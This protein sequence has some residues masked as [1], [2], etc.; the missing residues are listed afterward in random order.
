MR[1]KR[2]G[3]I[4]TYLEDIADV[5]NRLQTRGS[6]EVSP[7]VALFTLILLAVS[8]AYISPL[9]LR[10]SSFL[11]IAAALVLSALGDRLKEFLRMIAVTTF[12]LGVISTPLVFFTGSR[13]EVV[14]KLGLFRTKMAAEGLVV[15]LSFFLRCL[16]TT[17]I[18]LGWVCCIRFDSLL[19]GLCILDPT[20]T[21]STL[22]F[23]STRY[24]PLSL[25]EAISLL[26]AREARTMKRD[27]SLSWKALSS[28]GG[29]L[30][31]R[32]I[33]RGRRVG[34][35]ISA[36]SLCHDPMPLGVKKSSLSFKS[37]DLPPISIAALYTVIY[38]L[39]VV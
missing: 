29:E 5:L 12:S 35:A 9:P 22:L 38:A 14:L 28:T 8:T 10:F 1:G 17:S 32:A 20:Q 18:S 37:R 2:G 13:L 30:L 15:A 34:L 25:R 11:P 3:L 33:H 31:L 6:I 39:K 4:T 23:L 16:N 7:P 21:I 27:R 26:V 19:D 36:R 24:I